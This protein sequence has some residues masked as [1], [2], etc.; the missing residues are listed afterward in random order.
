MVSMVDL[1]NPSV[2][3]H[4]RIFWD[5]LRPGVRLAVLG[6]KGCMTSMIKNVV[7]TAKGQW[8][9]VTKNSRYVLSTGRINIEAIQA[10]PTVVG[11]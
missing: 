10:M 6:P 2:V 9:I 5:M 1:E 7:E 4:G 8:Y 11:A 3:Y